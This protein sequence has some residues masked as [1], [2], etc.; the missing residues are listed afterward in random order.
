MEDKPNRNGWLVVLIIFLSL[1]ILALLVY[2]AQD[3][4]YI[5]IPFLNKTNTSSNTQTEE[6]ET[7]QTTNTFTGQNI[8]ATL[9]TN[10]S[11]Q[12]F[13][14]GE[15][16]AYLAEGPS[17]S[18]L[19]GIKIFDEDDVEMFHLS[20]VN[21]IGYEGCSE[22]YAFSDDNPSYRAQMQSYADEI[23]DTMHINDLSTATYTE[24]NWLG[25]TTRRIDNV[26]YLD[27]EEGNNYFE[28]PCFRALI[29]LEGLH[30]S[31][32][33]NNQYESYFYGYSTGITSE[34]LLKID[35]ILKSMSVIE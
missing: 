25:T 2:I 12:E 1:L 21:G 32:E 4:G 11:M 10:W 8:S 20:A 9:P 16:T 33:D 18:G 19:T 34:Q 6:N 27:D 13:Y 3:K 31:D 14:N 35:D 26:L 23:Q 29:T 22:Y 7:T 15:G 5:Q 28:A 30:F 17:Y 24:F